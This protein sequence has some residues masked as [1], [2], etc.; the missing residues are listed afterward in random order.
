MTASATV[1][2]LETVAPPGPADGVRLDCLSGLVPLPMREA[3]LVANASEA[4]DR[5][6]WSGHFPHLIC[7]KQALAGLAPIGTAIRYRGRMQ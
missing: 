2:D 3:G 1:L 5:S 4:A 7:S 6:C